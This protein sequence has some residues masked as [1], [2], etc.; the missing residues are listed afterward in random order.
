[1]VI[2]FSNNTVLICTESF[3][4][5]FLSVI[6]DYALYILS[7]QNTEELRSF[8]HFD[9]LGVDQMISRDKEIISGVHF[10][11]GCIGRI[12]RNYKL[13]FSGY[14]I[15]VHRYICIL[16]VT[17]IQWYHIIVKWLMYCSTCRG[18]YYRTWGHQL[19]IFIKSVNQMLEILGSQTNKVDC[20][21]NL[22]F[23]PNK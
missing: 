22:V 5:S 15:C 11:V 6:S 20:K 12:V 17:S 4:D 18:L 1:M 21:L 9:N 2:K 19:D 13:N 7:I 23:S 10:F 8:I 3:W 16:E 14:I